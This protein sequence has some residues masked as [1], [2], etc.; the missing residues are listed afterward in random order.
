[1]A[2]VP[3]MAMTLSTPAIFAAASTSFDMFSVGGVTMMSS[4]TPATLAGMAFM[5]T[6]EGYAA[7]PPGT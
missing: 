1:M 2:C 4:P 5:S 3:P 6:L 7:V